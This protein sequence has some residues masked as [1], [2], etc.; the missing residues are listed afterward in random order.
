[1]LALV[2]LA[3]LRERLEITRVPRALAGVPVG[4]VMAG[5][6]SMAFMAFQGMIS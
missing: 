6:M 1:M 3:G 2:L 4:L 5:L